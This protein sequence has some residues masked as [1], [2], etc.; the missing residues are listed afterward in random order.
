MEWASAIMNILKVAASI[1]ELIESHRERGAG[2]AL[3]VN[4]A[5]LVAAEQTKAAREELDN[6]EAIHAA[7]P[8]DNAFLKKYQRE[9]E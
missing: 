5:L 3:A 1:M 2:Y 6:A 9:E 8:T 4:Q 7:D